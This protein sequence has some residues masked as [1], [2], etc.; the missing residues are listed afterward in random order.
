MKLAIDGGTP[1]RAE[2]FQEWPIF[3]ELE[4]RLLIEVLHSGKWGGAGKVTSPE[5]TPKLPEMEKKVAEFQGAKYGVAVPN[6]TLAITIALQAAGVK[7]GDEVIVPPYTFIATASAALAFGAIPVF[8]DIEEETLNLDPE[9]IE[10][11]ITSRTKAIIPVHIGGTIADMPRL[12]TIAQKHHL[13]II[14]DCAH[15]IGSQWEGTGAG[16]LGDLGTFSFQ[17]TKNLNSGEGGII[18][19]NDRELWENVWSIHNVGRSP[20]GAWYQHD[21]LGQNYRMTE[22]QAA[23]ILAQLTRLEEQMALRNKN[24]Q[25]L[26]KLLNDIEGIQPMQVDSRMTRHAYHLYCLK[27]DS[28]V[29]DRIDK[30]SFI[31]AVEAEG[32]PLLHGYLPLYR[33][34]AITDATLM[35]T[36]SIPEY[37]CPVCERMS[38]HEAAW[39]PHEVLLADEK[40]MYDIATALEKVMK[41]FTTK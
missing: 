1:V 28:G 38:D 37:S 30:K 16:M 15:A 9:K 29:V 34:K 11:A 31:K 22:F 17:S 25:L 7:P 21:R 33:N 26:T 5:F 23:I 41:V 3:G 18:L 12:K 24:A 2:G 13:R 14:E 39:L 35:L 27:L 6:G 20:K 8:V 19:T 10:A 40:A 32:I 36:G 4:E